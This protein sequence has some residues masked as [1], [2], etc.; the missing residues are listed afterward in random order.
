MADL[1]VVLGAGESGMGA[2]YLACK[3]GY[4]VFLSDSGSI[5]PEYKKELSS[6]N[7]AFEEGGHTL[8]SM[9]RAKMV[10][11]SPGI[12]DSAPI[13]ASL[14]AAGCPIISEIEFAYPFAPK[15]KWVCI[16]GSNG[17]TTT[18]TLV[19]ELLRAGGLNVGLAGNVGKSLARM[20]A[21]EQ[22]DY[23]VL[24]LS[25]FQLDGM[26][27][28]K[29]D[30]AILLNITPDHLDRYDHKMSNYV[31]SKF[32]VAQNMGPNDTLILNAD[33]SEIKNYLATHPLSAHIVYFSQEG[34]HS[35]GDV[36][37]GDIHIAVAQNEWSM[38]IDALSLKGKH[39]V[40]NSLAASMAA[41]LCSVSRET[42]CRV[43]HTFKGIEHR[44]EFVRE[45]NGVRY[46]NDSKATNVDSAWYALESMKTPVV[47]IAGGTD[48][49]N[50]YTPLQGF[51]KEK[52][53]TLICLGIEN[54]KLRNS[55]GDLVENLI[56]VHSAEAAVDAA[57]K[58]A[59]RGD[60]V[61][62]S[63]ACASFDLF[64]NYEDRGQ[65]FKQ[66]VLSL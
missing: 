35:A 4:E 26:Y 44:L 33:D 9:Q 59:Q 46:I 7:I 8:E 30:L 16:T 49:G 17:K 65:Q 19:Y 28:F 15:A 48:K 1:V 45:W 31:A 13:I 60:T 25:S 37:N 41:S 10:V 6:L 57:R 2:A 55:F 43:L 14:K 29:A 3:K 32:R 47:W 53:H 58:Y 62:L 24:E 5:K 51:V 40:Y 61:L 39:N 22:H 56:E 66:A 42:I 63:P 52:V 12:P 18:T 11:K 50:D 20:V 36:Q 23:Y 34:L 21:D 54:T 64:K 27:T 38:P